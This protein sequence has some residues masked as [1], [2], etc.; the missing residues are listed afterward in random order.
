MAVTL[1]PVRPSLSFDFGVPEISE[2][3]IA[4]REIHVACF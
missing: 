3:E 4:E 1:Q 2:G